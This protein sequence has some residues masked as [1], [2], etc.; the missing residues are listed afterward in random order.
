[1]P[2]TARD[3]QWDLSIFVTKFPETNKNPPKYTIRKHF[4]MKRVV[5]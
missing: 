4:L 5:H 1:M 2:S 3:T